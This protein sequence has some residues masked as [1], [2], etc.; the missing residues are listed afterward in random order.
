[1]PLNIALVGCGAIAR[2]FYLPTLAKLRTRFDRVW[3]VDPR[4]EVGAT[5][6]PAVDGRHAL[7]L[8]D[9]EDELHLTI[10]ATPNALHAPVAHEALGRGAHV[11]IEK[12]FVVAPEDGRRLIAA[13]AA[14]KRVIAVNQARRLYPMVRELRQRILGGEWGALQAVSHL[15]GVKLVWPFESGAAFSPGA[16]RT[17]AIMDFGVHVV[18]LYHYLFAPTWELASAIH[19]GFHG[20]EGLGEMELRASGAP[21]SIRLSR[22]YSQRNTAHLR[23][24]RAEVGFDVY[25]AN[26][27]WV[28]PLSHGTTRRVNNTANLT[29]TTHAEALFLNFIAAGE[30]REKPICDAVSSQPVIEVLDQVYTHAA[31]YPV[32]LGGV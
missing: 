22:Y 24:E 7:R 29:G 21:V 17:G 20:P 26:N 12:P 5:A 27:Y 10:V 18:D 31:R 2:A 6:A 8:A 9:V 13:A 1:M 14:A 4:S 30:G 32:A 25:D 15:E 3:L 19:D 23:F 28:R 11:L 16:E